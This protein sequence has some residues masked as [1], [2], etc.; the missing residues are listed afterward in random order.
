[1]AELVI[2][3]LRVEGYASVEIRDMKLSA[4]CGST[5][6]HEFA[7]KCDVSGAKVVV[8]TVDSRAVDFV[9]QAT[10]ADLTKDYSIR[11]NCIELSSSA[12]CTIHD[13]VAIDLGRAI[14]FVCTDNS[15]M[16]VTSSLGNISIPRLQV[17]TANRA[18]LLTRGK[19]LRTHDLHLVADDH[20]AVMGIEVSARAE[21]TA[22]GSSICRIEASSKCQKN[23]HHE[24]LA[25]V[26]IEPIPGEAAQEREAEK[27][28]RVQRAREQR[29][30]RKRTAQEVTQ[31]AID[32]GIF[33]SSNV[34]PGVVTSWFE[35]NKRPRVQ[36][37][38]VEP[39]SDDEDGEPKAGPKSGY[40]AVCFDK[41]IRTFCIPCGHAA[42][43]RGCST[44]ILSR[45]Q[46]CPICRTK[47]GGVSDIRIA[48]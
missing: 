17:V 41:P 31:A 20:S 42:L 3:C 13:A 8:E 18:K 34:H 11:L 2:T 46:P 19:K 28:E 21:I 24:T 47:I 27:F 6:P 26:M 39:L 12:Q 22:R 38:P 37:P 23:I 45:R 43:C 4:R 10:L 9:E 25:R 5:C 36:P 30:R 7:V 40:C 44:E 1:M 14:M 16:R 29:R 35:P 15:V 32:A 33:S 48:T